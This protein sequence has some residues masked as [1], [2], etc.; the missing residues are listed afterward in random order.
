MAFLPKTV[1]YIVAP[2]RLIESLT[3]AVS[4]A[5]RG[6]G[7]PED[8]GLGIAIIAGIEAESAID[9]GRGRK[10]RTDIELPPIEE[11]S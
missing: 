1:F 7:G 11:A 3:D 5:L 8:C 2:K 6:K 10:R 9:G 4:M